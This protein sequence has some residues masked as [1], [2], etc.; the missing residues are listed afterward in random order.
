M[1]TVAS[2]LSEDE[3]RIWS[4]VHSIV[5]NIFAVDR[6]VRLFGTVHSNSQFV[7][8]CRQS[9]LGIVFERISYRSRIGQVSIKCRSGVDQ[10]SIR[11]RSCINYSWDSS[12]LGRSSFRLAHIESSWRCI[13]CVL[14][15]KPNCVF[16]KWY[17]C[18]RRSVFRI[19]FV[20]P[21][22]SISPR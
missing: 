18:N 14:S 22:V 4:V 13:I 7:N 12:Y 19:R 10:V 3:F 20:F 16:A 21:S 11:C 15:L 8:S 9:L 5:F 6:L 2:S 17:F 1:N